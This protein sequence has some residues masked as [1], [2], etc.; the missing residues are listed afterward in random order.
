M[1]FKGGH[2]P[3]VEFATGQAT[4]KGE[5]SAFRIFVPQTLSIRSG[6]AGDFGITAGLSMIF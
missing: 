3:M 6:N 5:A 2:R 1:S 4:I